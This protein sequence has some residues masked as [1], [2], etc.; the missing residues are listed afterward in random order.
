MP[1]LR[2]SLAFLI[3]SF[4]VLAIWEALTFLDSR[5]FRAEVESEH[6][7]VHGMTP[8]PPTPIPMMNKDVT[9]RGALDIPRKSSGSTEENDVDW[10]KR[11]E[12]KFKERRLRVE[13][14]CGRYKDVAW[15]NKQ[16]GK[17]FLFDID[18]GL[19]CCRHGKESVRILYLQGDPS[20]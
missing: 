4:S 7:A 6:I 12:N 18:N 5:I 1:S 11:Q 16:V 20:G 13:A 8:P 14:V 17:E 3:V 2:P 19:A 9:T 15:T 10:M